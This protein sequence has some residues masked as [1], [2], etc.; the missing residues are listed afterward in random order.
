MQTGRGAQQVYV[1][2]MEVVDEQ[3]LLFC[4]RLHRVQM[5]KVP[6]IFSQSHAGTV[7]PECFK[8]DNAS[9]WIVGNSTP[10]PSKTPEPI[11]T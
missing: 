4:G 2:I 5:K 3:L 8:D 11:V 7:V 10:A 1:Y 6:L 9:Q